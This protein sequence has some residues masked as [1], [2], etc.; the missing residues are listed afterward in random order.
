MSTAFELESTLTDRYQTT[1]PGA[2]RRALKLGKRDKIHYTVQ[3]NGQVVIT[4]AE[5]QD[6]ALTAFLQFLARDM[7]EHPQRLQSVDANLAKRVRSAIS[8]VAIDLETE[9]SADDE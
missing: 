9:L 5:E 8:G 1:V 3:P 2:V 7:T 4:R 6:P